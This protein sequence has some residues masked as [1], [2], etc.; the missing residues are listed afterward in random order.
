MAFK[1]DIQT[2]ART[3]ELLDKT[4]KAL[5]SIKE[6]SKEGI[7]VKRV[8]ANV[9]GNVS[10]GNNGSG[11]TTQG[12]GADGA[13]VEAPLAP[14]P[15]APEPNPDVDIEVH[16]NTH[17][18]P[19]KIDPV[20][21]EDKTGTGNSGGNAGGSGSPSPEA[22]SKSDDQSKGEGDEDKDKIIDANIEKGV[23]GAALDKIKKDI[24]NYEQGT[25]EVSDVMDAAIK[26][27]MGIFDQ[28]GN[29][30]ISST[31]RLNGIVGRSPYD[32]SKYLYLR[33]DGQDVVPSALDAAAAGQ[34]P[35]AD[36]NTPPVTID[37]TYHTGLYW[38]AYNYPTDPDQTAVFKTF[39]EA[40]EKTFDSLI[41]Y[42]PDGG[43]VGSFLGCDTPSGTTFPVG[44]PSSASA[45]YYIYDSISDP[46]PGNFHSFPGGLNPCPTPPAVNP[47]VGLVCETGPPPAT[48]PD[49]WPETGGGVLRYLA[50][51]FISSVFDSEVPLANRGETS[52]VDIASIYTGVIYT[53]RPA[54]EG[55]FMI[56]EAVSPETAL[57]FG[58]DRTLRAVPPYSMINFYTPR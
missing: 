34:G 37:P 18:D 10:V 49:A 8:A 57:I 2:I 4:N 31:E 6:A 22:G 30:I 28:N 19:S 21:K 39:T 17:P 51:K 9:T 44:P 26:I 56:H 13:P 54:I 5:Q 40:Q 42:Y 15:K 27:A 16:D 3:Q 53:V 7:D 47:A 36:G 20:D 1:D 24:Y 43:D 35:W 48:S 32:D 23:A 45:F 52:Q 50:G 41:T 12:T 14:P 38:T 29:L 46:Y 11:D 25:Y 33:M 58:S 55:G